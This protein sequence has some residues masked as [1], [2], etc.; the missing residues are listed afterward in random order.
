MCRQ[1][2]G[3]ETVST[4]CSL[5]TREQLLLTSGALCGQDQ[6][7]SHSELQRLVDYWLVDRQTGLLPGICSKNQ[8]IN[9]F[10]KQKIQILW[11]QLL[12][13]DDFVFFFG[14]LI[15][16]NEASEDVTL[17]IF[18]FSSHFIIEDI[19]SPGFFFYNFKYIYW[20]LTKSI[21]YWSTK[22]WWWHCHRTKTCNRP[23]NRLE[24]G[25]WLWWFAAL[26]WAMQTFSG[27]RKL[28]WPW[29]WTFPQPNLSSFGANSTTKWDCVVVTGATGY[30]QPN[31][32]YMFI[33]ICD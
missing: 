17:D 24:D 26:T 3:R 7:I 1:Q 4:W 31:R 16:Q 20:C 23:N 6:S 13:Y 28:F 21:S 18:S 2:Q 29:P 22:C 9:S 19:S 27:G 8:I 12:K 30:Q 14:L 25:V 15:R 11:L 5:C 32:K 10:L 33:I